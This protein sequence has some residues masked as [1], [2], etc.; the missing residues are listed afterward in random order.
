MLLTRVGKIPVTA[1]ISDGLQT[2]T[3]TT[4]IFVRDPADLTPPVVQIHSPSNLAD[5]TAPT[6]IFGTVQDDN[7]VEVLLLYKRADSPPG[8]NL[9]IEEFTELYRGPGEFV[10]QA[11]ASLDTTTL[12]NGTYHI[13]LQGTDSNNNTSGR[14]IA[15]NV[16]DQWGQT[17]LISEFLLL[18]PQPI[19]REELNYDTTSP[20]CYPR[21]N[22]A[23]HS[24]R[25]NK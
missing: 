11:I 8:A 4:N 21:S 14:M 6:E 19:A 18:L 23:C 17:R 7:L 15:V 16:T 24:A 13:L 22:P 2:I 10:N 3:R 9:L 5:I 25:Q 12:L 1:V 20:F